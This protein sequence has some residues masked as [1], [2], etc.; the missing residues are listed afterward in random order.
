MPQNLDVARLSR[1]YASMRIPLVVGLDETPTRGWRWDT[2][3]VLPDS[4]RDHVR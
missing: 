1:T 4:R 2:I 3:R